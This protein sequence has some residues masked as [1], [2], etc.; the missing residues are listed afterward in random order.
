MRSTIIVAAIAALSFGT[1]TAFAQARHG[2]HG[3]D[4]ATIASAE[5]A[6]APFSE[7]TVRKVD[8]AGNKLTIAHGPLENLGMPPMTMVFTV[9]ASASLEGVS[10]GDRIR[11]VAAR[12]DGAFLVTAL[13][14]AN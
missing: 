3:A 13:E 8:A 12:V 10:V 5:G 1:G 9:T 6:A 14:P 11:F 2:G 7:G 4:H